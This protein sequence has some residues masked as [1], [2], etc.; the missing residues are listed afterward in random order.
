MAVFR[1]DGSG[2]KGLRNHLRSKGVPYPVLYDGDSRNPKALGII[3]YPRV[4]VLDKTGTVVWEGPLWKGNLPKIEKHILEILEGRSPARKAT[5]G[6]SSRIAYLLRTPGSEKAV[7]FTMRLDGSDRRVL[8]KEPLGMA[9]KTVSPDG[10]RIVFASDRDGNQE[11]YTMDLTGRRLRRLTVNEAYDG[12][13]TWSPDG[14]QIVFVS[15]RD[16]NKE[17]YVMDADGS[18]QLR[19]THSKGAEVGPV[20]LTEPRNPRR[21]R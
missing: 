13:P 9:S 18:N 10:K 19:L 3:S 16:G 1:K 14:K 6:H 11:I 2:L 5:P 17:V 7:V 12:L 20:W 8:E 15:S 4:F 21:L